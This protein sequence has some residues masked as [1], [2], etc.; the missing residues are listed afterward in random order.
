MQQNLKTCDANKEFC[1]MTTH[2]F[3]GSILA[4]SFSSFS[5]ILPIP[6]NWF[7]NS[8]KVS[9]FYQNKVPFLA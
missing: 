7:S 3:S 2:S 1:I 8:V 4:L 6:V 9:S 5:F